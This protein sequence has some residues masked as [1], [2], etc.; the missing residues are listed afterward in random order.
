VQQQKIV[1]NCQ[2]TIG[3]EF[4]P[5]MSSWKWNILSLTAGKFSRKKLVQFQP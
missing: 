2:L 3:L 1:S 5:P 4:R